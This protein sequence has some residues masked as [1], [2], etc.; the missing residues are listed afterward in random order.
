M[1]QLNKNVDTYIAKSADFAKEILEYLRNIIHETC[2]D[3]EE[4]IKWEYRIIL[5][6]ETIYV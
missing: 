2:L 6:K 3:V 1:S 4:D 5:T